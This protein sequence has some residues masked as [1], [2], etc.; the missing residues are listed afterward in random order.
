MVRKASPSS[1]RTY[2]TRQRSEDPVLPCILALRLRQIERTYPNQA[3]FIRA[4]RL[5]RSTLLLL[6]YG[7]GNP[8]LKTLATLARGLDVSVWSLLGVRDEQVREDNES[9]GLPPD[10]IVELL[11]RE[12]GADAPNAQNGRQL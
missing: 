6:R 5:S 11:A 9:F 1:V 10:S 3:A 7:R 2:K 8:T 12:I 4:S